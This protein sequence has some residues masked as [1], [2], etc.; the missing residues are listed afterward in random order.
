M[1]RL[2]TRGWGGMGI[3]LLYYEQHANEHGVCVLSG[4]AYIQDGEERR[5]TAFEHLGVLGAF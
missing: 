1:C 4:T 3:F 5:E 2:F